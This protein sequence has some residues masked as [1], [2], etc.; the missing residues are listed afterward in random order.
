MEA[1]LK[2]LVNELHSLKDSMRD[3]SQKALIDKVNSA[4]LLISDAGTV[5]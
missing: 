4:S 3:P 5:L 2:C 1:E